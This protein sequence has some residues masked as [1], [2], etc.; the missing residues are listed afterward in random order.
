MSEVWGVLK[1]I[2]QT[3]SDAVKAN[4]ELLG[5]AGSDE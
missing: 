2:A 4:L 3:T 5:I 1:D